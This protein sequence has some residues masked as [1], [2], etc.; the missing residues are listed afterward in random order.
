MLRLLPFLVLLTSIIGLR[1]LS[2]LSRGDRL[3]GEVV[4]YHKDKLFLRV[5]VDRPSALGARKPV[6]AQLNLGR[7]DPLLAAETAVG[8]ELSLSVT[9]ADAACARLK[10]RL[11]RPPRPPRRPP[12]EGLKGLSRAERTA[13]S[14]LRLEELVVGQPL[15]VGRIL[16]CAAHGAYL[17][18]GTSRAA[19]GGTRRCVDALLPLAHCEGRSFTQGELVAEGALRV[20]RPEPSSGRLLVTLRQES[21]ELLLREQR[22]RVERRRRRSRRPSV[23]SLPAGSI[24]EGRV[25][26]VRPFG[27]VVNIGARQPGLVHISELAGGARVGEVDEIARVGDRV[28]VEVLAG[29][30]GGRLRLRLVRCFPRDGRELAEQRTLLRRGQS[31]APRFVRAEDGQE[32]EP[33][34]EATMEA[35][36]LGAGGDYS[37]MRDEGEEPRPALGFGEEAEEPGEEEVQEGIDAF[38]VFGEDASYFEEKYD[39]D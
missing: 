27:L 17:D 25:E 21:A 12:P 32:D 22:E 26:R 11:A 1:P 15:G 10:V 3:T 9:S 38:E 19:S 30:G 13:G 36:S 7:A 33:A 23:D 34:A 8:R 39:F 20:L 35:T 29:S 6:I 28:E 5:P 37:P 18:V 24:R 14:A 31:L 16:S 2:S 4:S